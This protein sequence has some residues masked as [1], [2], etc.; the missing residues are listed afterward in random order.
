MLSQVVWSFSAD[1]DAE[2]RKNPREIFFHGGW[3]RQRVCVFTHTRSNEM[4][5]LGL[6]WRDF[7]AILL[8]ST[9]VLLR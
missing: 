6:K 8:L 3:E 4:S 7:A 5:E 9:P 2:K 1:G